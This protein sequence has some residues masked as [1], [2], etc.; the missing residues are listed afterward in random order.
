[1]RESSIRRFLALFAVLC[2]GSTYAAPTLTDGEARAF[3]E[4]R[5]RDD[6]AVAP[7]G[8]FTVVSEGQADVSKGKLTQATYV[9]LQAW[10]KA[11]VV[12]LVADQQY[13]NYKRGQ[14]FTWDQFHQQTQQG[15]VAKI[16]VAPTE[17]GRQYLKSTT[18][19]G[20]PYLS[21]PMGRFLVTKVVKNEERKKGVDDYRLV[22]VSY[23]A[24]YNPVYKHYLDVLGPPQSNSKKAIVLLK[25]DAFENKW[26]R[27]ASDLANSNEEFATSFVARAIGQ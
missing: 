16:A 1:M 6:V 4:A 23:N 19:S 17:L 5:W 7:I 18:G 26:K 15:I 9:A 2:A 13:E 12:S 25:W 27:V 8:K 24:E 11:G 14:G 3:L 10:A 20:L 21:I 22:M